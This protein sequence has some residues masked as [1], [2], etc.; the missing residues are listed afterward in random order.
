MF[1]PITRILPIDSLS[2]LSHVVLLTLVLFAHDCFLVANVAYAVD[3]VE[4]KQTNF[5]SS[6]FGADTS[7]S[8][9]INFTLIDGATGVPIKGFDPIANYAEI[10][11]SLLTK[12]TFNIRANTTADFAGKIEFTI[13]GDFVRVDSTKPY[14]LFDEGSGKAAIVTNY[15]VR[16][17]PRDILT[18]ATGLPRLISFSF[19]KSRITASSSTSSTTSSTVTTS[20]SSS[21]TTTVPPS[22]T[23][24]TSTTTTPATS[25]TTTIVFNPSKA[26]PVFPEAMGF[27]TETV[28]GSGRHLS[29]PRTSIMRVTNLNDS[30][31]G[32]LR[33][34]A[35]AATPRTCIF[36]ISGTIVLSSE[37]R[38]REPYITIAGQTA[39]SPGIL[40]R[41]AGLSISTHDVLIQHLQ[42]RPGD[43]SSG[44]RPDLRDGI[45]VVGSPNA[46]YNVVLDHLSVSWAIDENLST[47]YPNTHDITISHCIVSEALY[48]SIHPKGAHSMGILVGDDTQRI[49]IHRNLLAFNAWRNPRIK[50]NASVEF[51]SNLIYGWDGS[52]GYA[53]ADLSDTENVAKPLYLR[54]E[55]N[56]YKP[57]SYSYKGPILNGKPVS[58][59]TRAFV[60][61]NI[62]PTRLVNS[63][64]EWK[65]V[66]FSSNPYRV[67]SSP[68]TSP[69]LTSMLPE[70]TLTYVVTYSGSRPSDSGTVDNRLISEVISGKG[71]LKDCIS[72]CT[73]NAGGWP[74]MEVK[75][76]PYQ[77]PANPMADDN[78]DGYTNL[79]NAIFKSSQNLG[80]H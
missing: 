72:G 59:A 53:A 76:V 41:G 8:V 12:G 74:S 68:I 9:V 70:E 80:V 17:L 77:V 29:P 60:V 31:S 58:S 5:S 25:T 71:T 40:L 45:N 69:G 78:G 28:A 30:G 61:N 32:S 56:Y 18:N 55:G 49:S 47:W 36:D 19:V 23:P 42:V 63:G 16:A 7:T 65:V 34:C 4:Q 2:A 67:Y 57:A 22:T 13:N 6:E 62:G 46:A 73:R 54:F 20:T 3:R 48:N 44:P 33:A 52:S 38:V 66:S 51:V 43:G 39:P 75:Q 79:E 50:P 11:L 37:I 15:E 10:D 21:T 14:S 26:L 27:G 35:I 1:K 64:D 24:R